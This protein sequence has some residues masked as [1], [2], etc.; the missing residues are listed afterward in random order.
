[1]N[2]EKPIKSNEI[3]L[4]LVTHS[5]HG[6]YITRTIPQRIR[7]RYGLKKTPIIWLGKVRNLFSY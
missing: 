2:E 1:M 4:D 7:E 5:V 3:F 6:L